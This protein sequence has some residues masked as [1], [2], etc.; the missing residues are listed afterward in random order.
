L[1]QKKVTGDYVVILKIIKMYIKKEK[2]Q[3]K[4]KGYFKFKNENQS[5]EVRKGHSRLI[6]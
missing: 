2:S 1:E 3:G 4:L 5:W 6:V